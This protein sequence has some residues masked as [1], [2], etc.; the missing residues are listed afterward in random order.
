MAKSNALVG[1]LEKVGAPLLK[2]VIEETA[3]PPLNKLGGHAIDLIAQS[4]GTDPT[5]EAIVAR[6]EAEP[7]KTETVIKA[8]EASPDLILAGVQQQRETNALFAAEQKEPWWA[9]AWR[10]AGMWGLGTLWFWN[11]IVLHVLNAMFKIALPPTDL[12][13]LFQLSATYM[14]LYMG[15]HTIKATVLDFVAKKWGGA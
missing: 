14:A 10:P 11:V 6:Y 1:I 15:G 2:M 3:P 8:V 5:P 4:L 7:T 12:L 13:L 9:W